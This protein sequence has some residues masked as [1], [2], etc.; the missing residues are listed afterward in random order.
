MKNPLKLYPE[1]LK[2]LSYSS[3][4]IFAI[5]NKRSPR[6]MEGQTYLA[7]A[8]ELF[9]EEL[10]ALKDEDRKKREADQAE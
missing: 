8:M 10:K 4:A 7:K 6:V 5:G 3:E 1:I 2:Y 9:Q